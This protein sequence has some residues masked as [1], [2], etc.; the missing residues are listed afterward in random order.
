MFVALVLY[1]V[2]FVKIF[3]KILSWRLAV[4]QHEGM[5]K[6][7]NTRVHGTVLTPNLVGVGHLNS[8]GE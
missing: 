2:I 8:N 4:P 7:E 1:M 5:W 6:M 3:G